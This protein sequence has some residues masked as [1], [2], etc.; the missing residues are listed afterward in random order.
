MWAQTVYPQAFAPVSQWNFNGPR[1]R[2]VNGTG[3][4]RVKA[5]C[6]NGPFLGMARVK[7]V[8]GSL[9]KKRG[10]RKINRAGEKTLRPQK[11]AV[12]GV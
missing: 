3:E 11:G 7:N 4:N 2:F 12:R 6:E 9:K 5:Q 1:F 8:S 10:G